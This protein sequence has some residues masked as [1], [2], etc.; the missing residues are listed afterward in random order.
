MKITHLR[1]VALVVPEFER[2]RDFFATAWGLREAAADG[3]AAYLQTQS[4]EAF[5]LAL[6]AGPERRIERIAFGVATAADVRAAA[7]ELEAAGAHIVSPPAPLTTPGGGFGL[8]FLDP[9]RRCI[10]LSAEVAETSGA[11]GENVP[12]MLAH[13]VV[14]TTD[15]KRTTAFY[16]GA[17]GFRI[18]D[19]SEDVMSFLRCNP[20]HHSLA[21][22]VS[23]YPSLNHTSWTMS[24]IDALF[25]AQGRVRA[26]G[27][28]LLWGTGRHGPGSQVF[29]YFVEPSG[30]VSELIADGATIE[31]EAAWN[32]QVWIRKPEFMDLWG[33]AGPPSAE[34]RAAMRG[35][36]DPGYAAEAGRARATVR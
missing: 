29:N 15:L 12:Q 34:I 36:P 7:A 3:G 22:N 18:S 16:T 9:D 21:F 6:I 24:S 20:E 35:I 19:W 1:H 23:D 26:W 13:V 17:L 10:E 5:Q 27:S 4:R 14:N 31:D 32:P 2:S 28:P 8:Q 30:F 11:P 25:R 33:T